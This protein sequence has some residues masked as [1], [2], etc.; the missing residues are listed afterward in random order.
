MTVRPGRTPCRANI[1]SMR[2]LSSA[3]IAFATALP[4]MILALMLACRPRLCSEV[5]DSARQRAPGNRQWRSELSMPDME[6]PFRVAAVDL[7]LVGIGQRCRIHE[8]DRGRR[9]LVGVI[10]RPHDVVHA[11]LLH[12]ELERERVLGAARRDHEIALEVLIDREF[13]LRRAPDLLRAAVHEGDA[14]GPEM[15]RLA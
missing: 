7:R 14:P 12:G 3:R 2:S 10:D 9:R 11:Q 13:R 15:H 4:S 6:N 8:S 5:Y 1:R